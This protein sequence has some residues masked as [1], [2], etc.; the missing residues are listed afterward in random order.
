MF[1]RAGQTIRPH[2]RYIHQEATVSAQNRY[3]RAAIA[4][5]VFGAGFTVGSVLLY[6]NDL[7]TAAKN[8]ADATAGIKAATPFKSAGKPKTIDA[9]LWEDPDT[10]RSLVWGSNRCAYNFST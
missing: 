1:K 6:Y 4:A 2:L 9:N 3:R 7:K 10:L 8:D 5:G